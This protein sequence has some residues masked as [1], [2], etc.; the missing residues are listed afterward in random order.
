MWSF[1]QTVQV[2]Q[3]RVWGASAYGSNLEPESMPQG[4]SPLFAF[5]SNPITNPLFRNFFKFHTLWILKI[6]GSKHVAWIPLVR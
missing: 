6:K 2:L 4:A 5:L 3:L 1:P